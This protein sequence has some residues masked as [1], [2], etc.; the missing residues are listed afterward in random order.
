MK[1]HERFTI[2]KQPCQEFLRGDAAIAA[3]GEGN[4]RNLHQCPVCCGNRAWCDNCSTDHHD[5]GWE[6]CKPGYYEED[7]AD[8]KA[9][10]L[11]DQLRKQNW[12]N[13]GTFTKT[14]K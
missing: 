6:T 5:A 2:G 9:E 11:V 12:K 14:G 8:E 3:L 10:E 4:H 13:G 1:P 7:W